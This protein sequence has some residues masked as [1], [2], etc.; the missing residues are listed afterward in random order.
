[1][2]SGAASAEI[3]AASRILWGHCAGDS[4]TYDGP[5]LSLRT[6]PT[7]PILSGR[8]LRH[9]RVKALQ[10]GADELLLIV[11]TGETTSGILSGKLFE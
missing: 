1:M 8:T 5:N 4:H 10:V 2:V 7:I 3:A 11:D 9:D 6:R